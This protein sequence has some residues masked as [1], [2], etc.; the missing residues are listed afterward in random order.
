MADEP[1]DSQ[2]PRLRYPG[3]YLKTLSPAGR[4]AWI[5]G[6]THLMWLDQNEL[7]EGIAESYAEPLSPM[8]WEEMDRISP[9]QSKDWKR[10]YATLLA[11]LDPSIAD[12]R[13]FHM[14]L[15]E[16]DDV[17]LMA[18]EQFRERESR[19]PAPLA[20]QERMRALWKKEGHFSDRQIEEF[21][22]DLRK[23]NVAR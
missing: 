10:W 22:E 4:L 16:P 11:R 23:G 6:D 1:S 8:D 21:V 7:G 13:L 18:L 12:P 2:P 3:E 20:V 5:L 15:H 17:A 19:S 14:I 9:S